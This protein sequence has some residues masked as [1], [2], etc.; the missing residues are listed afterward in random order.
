VERSSSTA[1]AFGVTDHAQQE[2]LAHKLS[3]FEKYTNDKSC[4]LSLFTDVPGK[5]VFELSLLC[6]TSV[7]TLQM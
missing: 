2:H 5:E 3:F 7:S 6:D 4:L 1:T